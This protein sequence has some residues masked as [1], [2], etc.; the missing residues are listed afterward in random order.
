[1]IDPTIKIVDLDP[2]TWYRLE[3]VWK[4][5]NPCVKTLF[6]LEENGR[7]IRAVDDQN[8]SFSVEC[9]DCTNTTLFAEKL[10][11]QYLKIDRI[12]ILTEQGLINFSRVAQQ[13]S[14]PQLDTDEFITRSELALRSTPGISIFYRKP[15]FFIFDFWT[16]VRSLVKKRLEQNHTVLIVLFDKEKL[17]FH[18]I[19]QFENRK[20]KFLTTLDH[21]ATL[22]NELSL[23]RKRDSERIQ[24]AVQKFFGG[25]F[26]SI[27]LEK[28]V[29]FEKAQN[30]LRVT[31][32]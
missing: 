9:E 2:F 22:N 12:I 7:L 26:S 28:E 11:K 19:L 8:R 30:I 20:L 5:I 32:E 10:F 18:V 14:S 3:E 16:R 17:Y 27:L 21:I 29:F 13:D 1:M 6:V 24:Y 31:N 15:S 25:P 23:L 4:N